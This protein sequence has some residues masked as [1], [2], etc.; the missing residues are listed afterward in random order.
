M[1]NMRNIQ[2]PLVSAR[3]CVDLLFVWGERDG[4]ILVSR[5]LSVAEPFGGDR[6]FNEWK[7]S[8][9]CFHSMDMKTAVPVEGPHR[10]EAFRRC[11]AQ[12]GPGTD[13]DRALPPWR[14]I[15]RHRQTGALAAP[16]SECPGLRQPKPGPHTI[17]RGLAVRVPVRLCGGRPLPVRGVNA[18]W[19][20]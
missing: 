8:A 3:P 4:E 19:R 5:R 10:V 18:A 20:C 13:R 15:L 2:S 12:R 1:S 11:V 16:K 9:A 14:A 7:L 17:C 6:N